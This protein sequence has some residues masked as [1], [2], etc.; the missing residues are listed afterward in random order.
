MAIVMDI[1]LFIRNISSFHVV[2][3]E[4]RL[5]TSEEIFYIIQIGMKIYDQLK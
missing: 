4:L 2:L 5:L 1:N 3:I